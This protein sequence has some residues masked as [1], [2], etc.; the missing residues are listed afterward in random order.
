MGLI[1]KI[2]I[3]SNRLPVTLTEGGIEKSS[4]GLVS[5]MEG[6][7]LQDCQVSWLGWPG[8]DV[9]E[10]ERAEMTRKLQVEHGCTPVFLPDQLA[11]DHYEGLSNSSLWPLLHYMPTYFQYRM[12]W[13]EAYQTVNALFA[14]EILRTT[15]EDETIWVHDYQLMLLPRL[16][17]QARPSLRIGFFLHTPFPSYDIFRCHPNRE[18]LLTGLL[19]ADM[20]GFHTFGYLRNFRSTVLRLLGIDS[21]M[22]T[23]RHEGHTCVLG[24]HP[25]GIDAGRFE[26]EMKTQVFQEH[27]TASTA[28]YTGKRLVLSVERL[29]Y[30][31]GIVHRLD[32]I[33]LFLSRLSPPERDTIHFLGSALARLE[34]K[35]AL[36]LLLQRLP[37]LRLL[38]AGER[39]I[40]FMYW[41]RTKLPVAW[42]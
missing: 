23:V 30:T 33:E 37:N 26:R 1:S 17:W 29:D 22:T 4:G 32:A 40:P 5:A 11:K 2:T 8:R 16:L 41:G 6:V 25:I 21:N 3:V 20:I 13:W 14:E 9:P 27:C 7:D 34:A 42:K 31:K 18:A 12:E 15:G 38:G 10:V 35:I 36:R 19:G 39:V 24:V 28:A